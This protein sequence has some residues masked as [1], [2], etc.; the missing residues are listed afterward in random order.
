MANRP[1]TDFAQNI[2]KP[3]INNQDKAYAANIAPVETSPATSAHTA[4]TQIIYNGVLYDVTADIA[5]NDAL[6]TTG[7][8][9]NIAAADDVSEQISNVKNALSNET[10]ARSKLGAHNLIIND[11]KANRDVGIVVTNNS[12]GSV[13]ISGTSTATGGTTQIRSMANPISAGDY[14]FILGSS[15]PGSSTLYVMLC[16]SPD[17]VT[18]DNYIILGST[19]SSQLV[20]FTVTEENLAAYPYLVLNLA[21]GYANTWGVTVNYYPRVI[22]A[23]D[24]NRDF[25]PRTMTNE[26]LTKAKI[27]LTANAFANG[28]V[29]AL[30]NTAATT[31]VNGVTFTVNADKTVTV[32][33]GAGGAT[34][35]ANLA[36]NQ[37]ISESDIPKGTWVLSSGI[38]D[39]NC[40][41]SAMAYNGTTWVKNFGN[42]SQGDL[43]INVDYSGYDTISVY[44]VVVSGSIYTTSKTVKPMIAKAGFTDYVIH[45]KSNKELTDELTGN[46][47]IVEEKTTLAEVTVSTSDT[48]GAKLNALWAALKT[49]VNAMSADELCIP[50]AVYG[51]NINPCYSMQVT[52]L[53]STET[54]VD[55]D[56]VHTQVAENFDYI[57]ANSLKFRQS[58]SKYGQV[59]IYVSGTNTGTENTNTNFS[60]NGSIK[61]I[62]RIIKKI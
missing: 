22:V 5:A 6:A 20:S 25:S 34:A 3:Y 36:I 10:S 52:A 60:S 27:G 46:Y 40:Y 28:A 31:A 29:N 58:A 45:A 41:L 37:T 51:T 4:G 48:I 59:V 47:L 49:R 61:V 35:N 33:T 23:N 56:F 38:N 12:D 42:T 16:S 26:A 14:D 19:S 24:P 9:A 15:I 1:I 7:A 2:L 53:K 55:M 50:E 8:G 13:T 32:S 54:S 11:F 39:S 57:I 62:G 44:L 18:D 21:I 30:E 17:T 43:T